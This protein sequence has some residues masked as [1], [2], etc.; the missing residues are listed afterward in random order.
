MPQ[1]LNVQASRSRALHWCRSPCC[2]QYQPLG[3]SVCFCSQTYAFRAAPEQLRQR[4]NVRIGLVQNA[5]VAPTTAPFAEQSKVRVNLKNVWH[6]NATLLW[7]FMTEVLSHYFAENVILIV[8]TWSHK[9][10]CQAHHEPATPQAIV[11]RQHEKAFV[12]IQQPHT[13]SRI[14]V[15]MPC[16]LKFTSYCITVLP[17]EI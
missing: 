9:V 8:S 11:S 7:P 6:I 1:D 2:S 12:G 15:C 14:Y 10:P 16:I 5:I 13:G 4:R 17:A 3:L